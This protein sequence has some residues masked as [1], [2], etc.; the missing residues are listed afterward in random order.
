MTK[1]TWT[2]AVSAVLFVALAAAVALLPVPFV[3]WSPGSTVDLMEKVAG[4][5]R[6]SI[7]G[8]QS[9]PASGQLRLTTVAVT[10][11]SAQ[12]TLPEALLS[13]WLAAREVLPREAVFP[14]GVSPEDVDTREFQSMDDSQSQAIT[15]AL[16]AALVP[17]S[18]VPIVTAVIA[19]GPAHEKLKP[20]DEIVA[21]DRRK[22]ASIDEVRRAIRAHEVGEAV[23]FSV[24]RD[25][26]VVN[27]T[28]TTVSANNQPT[29][30]VVGIN[31]SIG[32]AY[33]PQISIDI[34]PQIGG[35]SAGLMMA[36]G[37]YERITPGDLAGGRAIA[38]TGT[39][40]AAGQVGS[41]GGVQEKIA[42]A[43]RAG[44]SVF[45]LPEGNCPDVGSPPSTLRLVKVATL[46][47]A[48]AA[49]ADLN[50][51]SRADAVPGCS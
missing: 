29:E 14:A 22:V 35:P 30:P 1:Q 47:E 21:I 40:T 18:E 23:V 49:L 45:L 11:A 39:V 3:S 10:K 50:D 31:L 32:Y 44:A 19:T 6:I 48:L 27:V 24:R 28:V 13:Y 8:A 36:L 15:A 9:Y 37:V 46:G 20:G 7:A 34:D 33:L 2:A 16:R 25:A 5:D 38:G 41:V 42:G 51:P 4:K 26:H 12:L 17:V 43:E